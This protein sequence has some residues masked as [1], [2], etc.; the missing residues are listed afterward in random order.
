MTTD[1][2][3]LKHWQRQSFQDV[4][5]FEALSQVPT[6]TE[7]IALVTK[8]ILEN[9]YQKE[10]ERFVLLLHDLFG[11]YHEVFREWLRTQIY[12]KL[13]LLHRSPQRNQRSAPDPE[14]NHLPLRLAILKEILQGWGYDYD[15]T[16]RCLYKDAEESFLFLCKEAYQQYDSTPASRDLKETSNEPLND[17]DRIRKQLVLIKKVGELKNGI[18]D[19]IRLHF[20]KW[21]RPFPGAQDFERWL[22][23]SY[24]PPGIREKILI[25]QIKLT[26]AQ[27][28]TL[29]IKSKDS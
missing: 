10:A 24:L 12:P 17:V 14:V 3:E 13:S 15:A 2:I 5:F 18:E 26:G 28:V 7:R 11:A 9:Q 6:Y 29:Q 20:E 21:P 19:L 1:R 27:N 8:L 25:A 4:C 22:E 23:K 16:E